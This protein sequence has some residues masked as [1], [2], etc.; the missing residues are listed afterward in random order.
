MGWAYGFVIMVTYFKF[1]NSI[2]ERGQ[3]LNQLQNCRGP[4]SLK[5]GL[6]RLD[7]ERGTHC[8]F[9]CSVPQKKQAFCYERFRKDLS[10]V[11]IDV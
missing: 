5:V 1:L 9:S 7:L 3:S 8:M 6:S 11:D 10:S 4:W 2:A